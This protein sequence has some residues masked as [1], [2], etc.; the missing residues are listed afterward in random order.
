MT[1]KKA[2]YVAP[3]IRRCSSCDKLYHDPKAHQIVYGHTPPD[4]S[5]L[6]EPTKQ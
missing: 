1:A 2:G 6:E 5:P 3:G 4:D